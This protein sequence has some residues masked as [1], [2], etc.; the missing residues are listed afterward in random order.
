M[1]LDLIDI[2]SFFLIP[3][4]QRFTFTSEDWRGVGGKAG[5]RSGGQ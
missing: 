5:K 1:R 2:D 3:P 4:A